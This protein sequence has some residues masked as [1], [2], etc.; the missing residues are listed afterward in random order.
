MTA[1][2]IV[3]VLLLLFVAASVIYVVADAHR[4]G[5]PPQAG[6]EAGKGVIA[7]YFH[8]DQRCDTCRTIEAYAHEALTGGFP[9]EIS[10][11]RLTWRVV[12]M[13]RPENEGYIDRFE[14][15][16]GGVVLADGGRWKN[17][18]KVWGLY[19]DKESF[20]AYVRKETRAFLDG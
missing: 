10:E 2:N 11:G 1:R 15:S 8:G 3:T 18:E 13:D 14:L 9:T 7:Y 20:V 12:N 19:F 6:P 5:A 4:A 17:L 16:H